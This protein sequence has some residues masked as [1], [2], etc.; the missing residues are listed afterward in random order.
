MRS[1]LAC[2]LAVMAFA[3]GASADDAKVEKI[4][5]AKLVGRWDAQNTKTGLVIEFTKDGKTKSAFMLSPG[6]PI[7]VEGTYTIEGNKLIT[8]VK[9]GDQEAKETLTVTKLTDTELVGTTERGREK[10]FVRSKDK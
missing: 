7:R 4:D 10:A 8:V 3:S 6:K 1:R 5:P 2:A 9:S